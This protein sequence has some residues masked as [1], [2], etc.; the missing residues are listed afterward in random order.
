MP[1]S[2]GRMLYVHLPSNHR[3]SHDGAIRKAKQLHGLEKQ[4]NIAKYTSAVFAKGQAE[5]KKV[6]RPVSELDSVHPAVQ[7]DHTL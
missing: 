6:G 1:E 5:G 2:L 4:N 3:S 7:S